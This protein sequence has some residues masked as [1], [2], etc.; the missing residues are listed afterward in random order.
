[1]DPT[2]KPFFSLGINCINPTEDKEAE[3]PKYD[4]LARHG[5]SVAKWQAFTH[6]YSR[7]LDFVKGEVARLHK[8]GGKPVTE[9]A[10]PAKTNRSGN[11]NKASARRASRSSR[12]R[13][14]RVR[15]RNINSRLVTAHLGGAGF[16]P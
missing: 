7:D 16:S 4:G 5:G 9:F 10:F 8:A 3:P 6:F 1:V 13:P 11:T 12:S 14:T 2:G 15:W